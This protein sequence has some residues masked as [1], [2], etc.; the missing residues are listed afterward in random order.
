MR[1]IASTEEGLNFSEISNIQN[2]IRVDFSIRAVAVVRFIIE[3]VGMNVSVNSII[4][5]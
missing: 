5:C 1:W 2:V 4:A 3:I